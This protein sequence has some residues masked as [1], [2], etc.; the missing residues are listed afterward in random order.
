MLIAL[1][2]ET[3]GLNPNRDKIIEIAAIKIKEDGTILEEFHALVHPGVPLPQIITHI[4]GITDEE[5]KDAQPLEK[6]ADALREF[7]GDTPT[8][9]G[10]SIQFDVD[11]LNAAGLLATHAILDTFELAQTLLPKEDSYSL[12]ILSEKYRLPHPNKHR[13]PDDT[14]V[15]IE[16]YKM[17][18]TVAANIPTHESETIRAILEKSSWGWKDLLLAVVGTSPNTP[19]PDL[20]ETEPTLPPQGSPALTEQLLKNWLTEQSGCIEAPGLTATDLAVAATRFTEQSGEHVMIVTPEPEKFIE[21]ARVAH[22]DHPSRILNRTR[23][24]TFLKKPSFSPAETRLAVKVLRWLPSTH[25]GNKSELTLNDDEHTHWNDLSELLHLHKTDEPAQGSFYGDAFRNAKY[26]PVLVIHPRLLFEQTVRTAPLFPAKPHLVLDQLETLENE[27]LRALTNT[28][29]VRRL[30]CGH[31]DI[32]TALEMLFGLFGLL[33]EKVEHKEYE[34]DFT[35]EEHHLSGADGAKIKDTLARLDALIPSAPETLRDQLHALQKALELKPGVRVWVAMQYDNE[36]TLNACPRDIKSFAAGKLWPRFQ[37][38]Q[39]VSAFGTVD[40]SFHFLKNRLALPPTLTETLLPPPHTTPLMPIRIHDDLPN[41]KVPQNLYATAERLLQTM[42]ESPLPTFVLTNSVRTAEQ[43]HEVLI[44]RAD[45]TQLT[46]LTQGM[47]GGIGKISHLFASN[48]QNTL[49]I[50]TE[51]LYRHILET[52]TAKHLQ[53]LMIYRLPFG[54]VWHPD[55]RA[56]CDRMNNAFKEYTLPEGALRFKKW[57]QL[58]M[59]RTTPQELHVLDPRFHQYDG[60]FAQNLPTNI[61][62]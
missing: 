52:P 6:V 43:L 36:A 15:A 23:L 37:T 3:T 33:Y 45:K 14:R 11:F 10:H 2:L 31:P 60:V 44:T 25:T 51:K 47:S 50:G 34:Q 18:R 58:F 12:E 4:T 35:L 41:V 54:F 20:K 30:R 62:N 5:L 8:I 19:P 32:D 49:L 38:I 27:A 21:D 59:D 53:R 1:D 42:T 61:I 46:V 17:L 7:L 48:P 13:A 39:A 57:L 22:L 28:F 40:G 56:E 16:L 9:L 55:L 29:S 24:E 26:T